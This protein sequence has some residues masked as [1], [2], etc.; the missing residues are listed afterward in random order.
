MNRQNEKN[1]IFAHNHSREARN[2]FPFIKSV[3]VDI[4]GNIELKEMREPIQKVFQSRKK[5][6]RIIVKKIDSMAEYFLVID[7][8][9][10]TFIVCK[11]DIIDYS[12]ERNR[13]ISDFRL[14]HNAIFTSNDL[15]KVYV[16]LYQIAKN[17]EEIKPFVKG[18]F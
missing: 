6:K 16:Y 9:N 5:Q 13:S 15:E 12:F 17:K 8:S 11:T 18:L 14:Y 1:L 2:L 4:A 7:W 3:G 10:I